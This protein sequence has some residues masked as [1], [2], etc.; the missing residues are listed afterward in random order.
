MTEFK[1][2]FTKSKPKETKC[3]DYKAFNQ[4]N[5]DKKLKQT[6]NNLQIVAYD[7]FKNTFFLV[8]NKHASVKGHKIN[9]KIR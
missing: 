3:R 1:T 7:K 9:H 6:L 8:L 5:F 4:F 2:T